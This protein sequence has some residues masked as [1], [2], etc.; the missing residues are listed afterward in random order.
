[1]KLVLIKNYLCSVRWNIHFIVLTFNVNAIK[2]TFFLLHSG[3]SFDVRQPIYCYPLQLMFQGQL[4]S[5][6]S[7]TGILSP[8]PSLNFEQMGGNE[9]IWGH[10]FVWGEW[11]GWRKEPKAD[12]K[13]VI[14]SG[15]LCNNY[16]GGFFHCVSSSFFLF[17]EMI[18]CFL[19]V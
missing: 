17:L 7:K 2:W 18:D 4:R 19:C 8:S 6:I 12:L 3:W 11:G 1:M 10:N 9:S 5:D 15:V 14:R 13:I 16:L